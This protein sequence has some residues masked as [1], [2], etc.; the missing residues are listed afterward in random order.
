ML[1]C[2]ARGGR[3]QKEKGVRVLFLCV[4]AAQ[5]SRPPH[6]LTPACTARARTDAEVFDAVLDSVGVKH[7]RVPPAKIAAVGKTDAEVGERFCKLVQTAAANVQA[8][9]KTNGAG[10]GGVDDEGGARTEP[11]A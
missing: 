7:Q 9:A 8:H 1:A 2:A 3:R 6:A 5:C 10:G 4:A 11:R